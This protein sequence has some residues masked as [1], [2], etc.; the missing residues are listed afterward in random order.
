MEIDGELLMIKAYWLAAA[1]SQTKVNN[2]IW[3]T[4]DY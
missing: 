1:S 2:N 4:S 3:E